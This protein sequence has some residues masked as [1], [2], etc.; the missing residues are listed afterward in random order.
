MRRV[1]RHHTVWSIESL[2]AGRMVIRTAA[3]ARDMREGFAR[4]HADNKVAYRKWLEKHD[5]GGPIGD[6]Y[7]YPR[8]SVYTIPG[9][10]Y[11]CERGWLV[12]RD[13]PRLPG[14]EAKPL[15][16]MTRAADGGLVVETRGL[17]GNELRLWCGPRCWKH[18]DLPDKKHVSWRYA[19]PSAPADNLPVDWPALIREARKVDERRVQERERAERQRRFQAL[20]R[21]EAEESAAIAASVAAAAADAANQAYWRETLPGWLADGMQLEQVN[22]G[23]PKCRAKG[24]APSMRD[25]SDLMRTADEARASPELEQM[26][27]RPDGRYSFVLMLD[28][29]TR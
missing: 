21:A 15:V 9:E 24:N 18:Y 7:G 25:V 16:R 3:N 17:V 11:A 20:L 27:R 14:S 2:D 10:Y 28:A 23:G 13:P 4:W 1:P 12:I 19:A 8:S 5:S 22:C 26:E 29:R 6:P